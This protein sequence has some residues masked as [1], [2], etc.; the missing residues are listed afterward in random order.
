MLM[1]YCCQQNCH[2]YHYHPYE[3]GPYF[4]TNSD[5]CYNFLSL[6]FTYSS[7]P[8]T[9]NENGPITRNGK[10]VSAVSK[11]IVIVIITVNNTPCVLMGSIAS[12][13]SLTVKE[14]AIASI[15]PIG[16]YLPNSITSPVDIFQNGVSADAP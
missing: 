6:S 11:N 3:Y 14:P 9:Y 1:V 15:R 4:L 13:L 8:L 7:R 16:T 10:N 2:H 12:F 5:T